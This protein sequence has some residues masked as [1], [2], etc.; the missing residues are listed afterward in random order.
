MKA[1]SCKYYLFIILLG[2]SLASHAAREQAGDGCNTDLTQT[3]PDHNVMHSGVGSVVES[4]VSDACQNQHLNGSPVSYAA[5]CECNKVVP[6]A[7]EKEK[8]EKFMKRRTG[9]HRAIS[10]KN[11]LEA[12][13]ET[14]S[15]TLLSALEYIKDSNAS[16]PEACQAYLDK[17][18]LGYG[19]CTSEEKLDELKAISGKNS[20]DD[21]FKKVVPD[22]SASLYNKAPFDIMSFFGFGN[23]RGTGLDLNATTDP[24]PEKIIQRLERNEKFRSTQHILGPAIGNIFDKYGVSVQKMVAP[25]DMTSNSREGHIGALAGQVSTQFISNT[26]GNEGEKL[27][28]L[29]HEFFGTGPFNNE[30]PEDNDGRMIMSE[31]AVA[32]HNAFGAST[33]RSFN[34]A[35]TVAQ[36]FKSPLFIKI[37]MENMVTEAVKKHDQLPEGVL[38]IKT[39]L[40]GKSVSHIFNEQEMRDLYKKTFSLFFFRMMKVFKPLGAL[41]SDYRDNFDEVCGNQNFDDVEY[42]GGDFSL[43]ALQFNPKGTGVKVMCEK[44]HTYYSQ[45]GDNDY[46]SLNEQNFVGY[47]KHLGG[48][49][50][51]I[52]VADDNPQTTQENRSVDVPGT[53]VVDADVINTTTGETGNNGETG[54]GGN[55]STPVATTEQNKPSWLQVFDG[56]PPAQTNRRR[57]SNRNSGGGSSGVDSGG[58]YSVTNYTVK[59]ENR[60]LLVSAILENKPSVVQDMMNGTYASSSRRSSRNSQTE[61]GSGFFAQLENGISN[62]SES[63]L[64]VGNNFAMYGV[65]DSVADL[66]NQTQYSKQSGMFNA[67]NIPSKPVRFDDLTE[68]Q[69]KEYNE[70]VKS[71]DESIEDGEKIVEAKEEEID[72]TE[73]RSEQSELQKQLDDLKKSIEDLKQQREDMLTSIEVVRET[74]LSEAKSKKEQTRAPASIPSSNQ[75]ITNVKDERPRNFNTASYSSSTKKGTTSNNYSNNTVNPVDYVAT[76]VVTNYP[77][78][79]KS[80]GTVSY[81]NLNGTDALNLESIVVTNSDQVIAP[82]VFSTYEQKQFDEYYKDHGSDPIV[83]KKQ[84]EITEGDSVKVQDVYEYYF[85]QIKEGKVSYIKRKPSSV[86]AAIRTVKSKK[87][88]ESEI[89]ASKRIIAKHE[90]LISLFQQATP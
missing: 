25:E 44:A 20:L 77:K 73:S 22:E 37:Y 65:N 48:Y 2:A 49:D 66:N 36:F 4:V 83:V 18:K 24:S 31:K 7:E 12:N 34:Q 9:I 51:T 19:S 21:I 30:A 86:L 76:P 90:D 87:K 89:D 55:N 33:T 43:H 32:Y 62:N 80:S 81:K 60:D 68:E 67:Q 75:Y 63:E 14:S 8:F 82:D 74:K 23:S 69:K 39:F 11:K 58:N 79:I 1:K 84:V 3:Q 52:L 38:D 42:N 59:N 46:E 53:I 27:L 10:K 72:S 57:N 61:S 85:P 56:L 64:M 29:A 13:T 71:L 15:A 45:N 78:S 28:R 54:D 16:Y 70:T 40:Q 35:V 47:L 41:C 17:E 26:N 6:T 5:Y 50:E 88:L